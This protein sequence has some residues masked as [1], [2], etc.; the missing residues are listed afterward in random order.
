M[1]GAFIENDAAVSDLRT[2][3]G[4]DAVRTSATDTAAMAHDASHYLLHPQ[5][6]YT[7]RD[8]AEVADALRIARR[9]RLPVTFRSAGTSLSGQASTA[10]LL[11]DTRRHFSAMEVLDDGG[12]VRLQPGLTLRQVNARLAAYGRRLGPDP[13]SE[14]ACTIG[15]VVANNSSGMSCGT[16]DTAYRT[17][18]SM[19][20]V[21]PSGTVLDTGDADAEAQL[22]AYEPELHAGLIRLRDRIRSSSALRQ[23]IEHQ[24]S[25][26]NTM[27]YGLNAF[28]DVTDPVDILTR[29]V[30]GSEGTLGFVA[31]VTMRT[32]PVLPHA[33]TTLLVFDSLPR[34][35]DALESLVAS[36]ARAIELLDASSLRVAQNDPGA[37]DAITGIDVAEHTALLV[38]YQAGSIGELDEITGS[39]R[40]ALDGLRLDAPAALPRDAAARAQL[41][42]VR[43]GLYTAVAGA[44][45]VGSTALLEDVVVPVPVLTETVN[46]LIG[47]FDRHGYTDAVIFGHAKDG[48]LHFMIN[49]MLGD[50]RELARYRAFTDDLVDLV[51]GRDGSLKA[52][53][54]TGRIMAPFVRRQFGDDL[55][56]IMREIKRLF[57]PD[58]VLNPGVLLNDDPDAHLKNLKTLPVVDPAVDSCVECGYCEPVCPSR[59]TTTTPR[60]RIVLMREIAAA[61]GERRRQL[62]EEY[63]YAAVDTCAADSLCVSAC[64]VN[65]DTGTVMKGMRAQ[66]HGSAAQRAG[67]TAARHWGRAVDGVRAG[68]KVSE[69]IPDPLL[70]RASSAG[71]RAF[72][73]GMVPD[74]GG[75]LPKAGRRRPAPRRPAGAS[76]V[77]FPACIGAIFGPAGGELAGAGSSS[78]FLKLCE[79]AGL[80]VA[81]PEGIANMCCGTPWAS[82]G[83]TRGYAEM[84]RQV[85]AGLWEASRFGELPVACDASSCAHGLEGIGD[86]L[87]GEEGERF[88]RLT[89]VDAVT[90]A[91]ESLLPRLRVR[92][93]LP[94]LAVHPTC[95]SVHM[96][97]VDDVRAVAGVVADDVVVPTSWGCCGFAGDRGLFYPELTEGATEAEAAELAGVDVTGYVSS[98][99]TCEMGM[100]RATGEEYHHVLELLDTATSE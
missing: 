97:T 81:I 3:A 35:T 69:A 23:T 21:L 87:S 63:E 28:L 51:L 71:R 98:N 14:T 60:Q 22:R 17:I 56:E 30:V 55:Y 64:P 38:E 8:A 5:A 80:E 16:R 33:A 83:F 57:D 89:I 92:R 75:G 54:G 4:G 91:R 94:S 70:A 65:I 78:A 58:E 31:E 1:T 52:E 2:L 48:N 13:A 72:G 47:L 93:R 44:R 95:S 85:F 79:R 76:V 96:G 77:F 74:A 86:A 24:F 36:G 7:A 61:S 27:G 73:P 15:G 49:P 46:E 66:Q 12:R 32:V 68:L 90:F 45:P 100:A 43:K 67:V 53:H 9:H 20:L 18:E 88:A 29:L 50:A 84:A 19:V 11:V 40:R 82:K 10:G 26:K 41:W 34:A 6:V 99:R 42:R 39:A 62:E 37:P 59:N 25:M